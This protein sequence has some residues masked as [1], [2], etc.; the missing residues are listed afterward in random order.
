[1]K[2][3]YEKLSPKIQ[4]EFARYENIV[5]LNYNYMK[6]IGIKDPS[7]LIS[8]IPELFLMPNKI[9]IKKL[10]NLDIEL[11]NNDPAM[12]VEVI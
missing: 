7:Q 12:I 11:I 2:E 4:Q 6:S 8:I 10:N 3:Q 5:A 1:M 9:L